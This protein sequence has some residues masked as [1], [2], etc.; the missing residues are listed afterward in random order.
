MLKGGFFHVLREV[1]AL[2]R[3]WK[4]TEVAFDRIFF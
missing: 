3:H 1:I 4:T 2:K